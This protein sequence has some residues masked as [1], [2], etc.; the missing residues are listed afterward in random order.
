[1]PA[2]QILA[3]LFLSRPNADHFGKIIESLKARP[4]AVG[5]RRHRFVLGPT[6]REPWPPATAKQPRPRVRQLVLVAYFRTRSFGKPKQCTPGRPGCTA[7][8]QASQI[9][10]SVAHPVIRL[11]DLYFPVCDMH[12][13][14]CDMSDRQCVKI[15]GID[16]RDYLAR[17]LDTQIRLLCSHLLVHRWAP[18]RT[19]SY[20]LLGLIC[21]VLATQNGPQVS[22]RRSKA[23]AWHQRPRSQNSVVNQ[24]MSFEKPRYTDRHGSLHLSSTRTMW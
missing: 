8:Q 23:S 5:V 16:F 15:N 12:A 13:E 2:S 18:M 10:E 17:R 3:N 6:R 19:R 7:S 9:V 11:V 4:T 21:L 14:F 20:L 22:E 24:P 1:M